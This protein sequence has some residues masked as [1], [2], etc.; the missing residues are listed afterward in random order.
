MISDALRS[1]LI[2]YHAKLAAGGDQPVD[3]N[4]RLILARCIDALSET[5]A[6]VTAIF[7]AA[8][9]ALESGDA[10]LAERILR[11]AA[12]LYRDAPT[13]GAAH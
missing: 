5:R 1:D 10:D 12:E 2:A 3:D 13:R 7:D 9:E 8:I 4:A 11:G 6:G